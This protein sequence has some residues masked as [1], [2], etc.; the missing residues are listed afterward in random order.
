MGDRRKPEII[1]AGHVCLDIIPTFLGAPADLD[2]VLVPGKLIEMG[3]AVVATGGTVSNAGLAL[4]RLGMAVGL[5]GKVGDDILGRAILEIFSAQGA[6]T[7]DMIVAAGEKTSYT[8]VLSPPGIDRIFLH[9]PG[10]N[11]T[12]CAADL[13]VGKLAGVRLLHVGY[14][15]LMARMYA[16]GGE[17]L[18]HLL[19]AA[20]AAGVTVSLDMARPDPASAAGRADW[21]RILAQSLPH[22]DVFAPSID[23]ILFMLDRP[24]F[25]ALEATGDLVGRVDAALVGDVAGELLSMGAAVVALK[26]GDRGLYLRATDDAAR[27]AQTGAC[28]IDTLDGWLGCD[29]YGPCFQA[30]VVGTTGSGDCTVAGVL[31]GILKGFSA[32]KALEAGLAVGACN[33]EAPDATSGVPAWAEVA[34]RVDAGWTRLDRIMPGRS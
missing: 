30:N 11:D 14:P 32:E 16:D 7:A 18:S 10:A 17:E 21:R 8:V 31:T 28:R 23:E 5:M 22:V 6:D 2:D 13:D 3:Q 29:L 15:P 27:L 12:Y 34:R 20:R 25:D 4:H 26:L 33:V 24:R 9:C 1:V 19:S